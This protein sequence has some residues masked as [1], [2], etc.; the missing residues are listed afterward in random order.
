[1]TVHIA[2]TLEELLVQADIIRVFRQD[3]AHFLGQCIHF[4]VGFCREQIEEDSR[5]P[6]KQIIIVIPLLLVVN[7]DDS[8]VK[9]RFLGVVDNLLYLF[10][11]ATDAF[12]HSF[13]IVLQTDTVKG[14][15]VMRRIIRLE[16]RIF[17]L[18]IVHIS[19]SIIFLTSA[20]AP[21]AE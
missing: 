1:M 13:L 14:G 6:T 20:V 9:S 11:I 17:S 3:G 4:V 19:F 16:E 7:T 2:D 8:I 15:Y 10:V 12:K 21:I 18:L 5:H